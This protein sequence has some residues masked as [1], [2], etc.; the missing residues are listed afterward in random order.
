MEDYATRGVGA[1]AGKFQRFEDSQ[2]SGL[3]STKYLGY[4]KYI[5]CIICNIAWAPLAHDDHL[6]EG[7][8][9]PPRADHKS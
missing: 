9:V 4:T 2:P 6:P 1:F 7:V 5:Q 3:Y 8:R